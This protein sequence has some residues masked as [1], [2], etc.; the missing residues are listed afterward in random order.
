VVDGSIPA[1][2]EA[3]VLKTIENAPADR[4]L[5]AGHLAD[6]LDRYI[7]GFPVKARPVGSIMHGIRWCQRNPFTAGLLGLVGSL[8]LMIA[9][10][11]SAGF[12]NTLAA[13]RLSQL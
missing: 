6:D 9:V 8:L 11:S 1:D 13:E 4:Y 10:F 3:I 12:V 2:L 7:E 5:T